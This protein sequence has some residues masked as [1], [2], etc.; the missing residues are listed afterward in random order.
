VENKLKKKKKPEEWM[1][2]VV[3]HSASL[4]PGFKF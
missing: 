3:E 4:K 2:S 1:D